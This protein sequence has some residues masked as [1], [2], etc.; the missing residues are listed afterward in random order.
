M[1]NEKDFESE[2]VDVDKDIKV[3][4]KKKFSKQFLFLMIMAILLIGGFTSFALLNFQVT[5]E[6]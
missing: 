5:L 6:G 4:K 2:V 1:E 3:V